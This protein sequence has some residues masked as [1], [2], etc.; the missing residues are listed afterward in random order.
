MFGLVFGGGSP[1]GF[2]SFVLFDGAGGVTFEVE[3]RSC[4]ADM[5]DLEFGNPCEDL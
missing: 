1:L 3:G 2:P 4:V 5:K